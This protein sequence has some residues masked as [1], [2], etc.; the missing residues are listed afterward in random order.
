M[1]WRDRFAPAGE[2]EPVKVPLRRDVLVPLSGSGA[3]VL[4]E[5]ARR[6]GLSRVEW[7]RRALAA[8]L[9]AE[10]AG[11]VPELTPYTGS[12]LVKQVDRG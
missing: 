3:K 10:G 2:D 1:S 8:Q 4:S 5:H 7:I 6:R 9:E 12:R 11:W